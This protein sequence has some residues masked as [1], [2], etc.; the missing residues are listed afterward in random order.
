MKNKAAL[1]IGRE[2]IPAEIGAGPS[3]NGGEASE[4]QGG[5][6]AETVLLRYSKIRVPL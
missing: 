5:E 3:R 2:K 1:G 6:G 4:R